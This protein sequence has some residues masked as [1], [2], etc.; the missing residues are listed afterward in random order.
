MVLG[1]QRMKWA[2][3]SHTAQ[4]WC[5]NRGSSADDVHAQRRLRRH[6]TRRRLHGSK[7]SVRLGLAEAHQGEQLQ[8]ERTGK[9]W[10]WWKPDPR[11]VQECIE[12]LGPVGGKTP[13]TPG[14]KDTPKNL[15]AADDSLS[16]VESKN[17]Q[18]QAGKMLCHSSD[19]PTI[20]VEMAKVMSSMCQ[21]T[22][23]GM[24]RLMRVMRHSIDRPRL[25]GRFKPQPKLAVLA[26]ADHT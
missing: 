9:N 4:G 3:G 17:S 2:G 22:V 13:S 11:H 21:P 7:F 14:T 24:A 26:D 8:H 5:D 20:Q 15:A 23:G 16:E 19:D 1:F 25:S 10:C 18:R 6:N 12:E